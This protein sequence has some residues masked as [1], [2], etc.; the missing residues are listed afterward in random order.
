MRWYMIQSHH[1][2]NKCSCNSLQHSIVYRSI[3]LFQPEQ[4][5][6]NPDMTFPEILLRSSGIIT[7]DS[8]NPL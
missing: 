5:Q 8:H 7:I 3:L 6:Q 4:P 2:M 1:L